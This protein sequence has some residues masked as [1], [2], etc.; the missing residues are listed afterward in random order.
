MT[1]RLVM[2]DFN[3]RTSDE[4]DFICDDETDDFLPLDD[5]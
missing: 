2:G 4:N 5:Y 1:G 3:T